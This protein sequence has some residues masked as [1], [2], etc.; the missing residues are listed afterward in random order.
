[1]PSSRPPAL[2]GGDEGGN[3]LWSGSEEDGALGW[4]PSC[5]EPPDVSSPSSEIQEQA[6]IPLAFWSTSGAGKWL[7][8]FQVPDPAFEG[9]CHGI[10]AEGVE[11]CPCQ[12]GR[13][14]IQH[15]HQAHGRF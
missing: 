10:R 8:F 4:A 3:G 15:V 9:S 5:P 7:T 14:A 2:V 6:W 12:L 11:V 13:A 1:M